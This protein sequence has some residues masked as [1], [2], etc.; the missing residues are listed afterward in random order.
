[1]KISI[2][3]EVAA[4]LCNV[5]DAWVTPDD[6]THWNFASDEWCCPKA[7]IDLKVGGQFNYRMEAKDG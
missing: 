3:N 6:I 2:E 7:E 4:H 5:W 1:M